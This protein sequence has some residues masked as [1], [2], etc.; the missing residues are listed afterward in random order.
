[1]K[2][3]RPSNMIRRKLFCLINF[4]LQFTV[5]SYLVGFRRAHKGSVLS[6]P[7]HNSNWTRE[8]FSHRTKSFCDVFRA[9]REDDAG[10]L[11]SSTLE[12]LMRNVWKQKKCL[13]RRSVSTQEALTM[14]MPQHHKMYVKCYLSVVYGF[15]KVNHGKEGAG[16]KKP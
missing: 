14:F 2:F 10:R 1:M 4:S 8:K 9:S 7:R 6:R 11:E 16:H 13:R 3:H 15:K 12:Q 5:F